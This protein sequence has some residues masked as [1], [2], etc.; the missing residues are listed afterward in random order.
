MS[1]VAPVWS[2]SD[3]QARDSRL[4]RFMQQ[5]GCAS[6]PE[7]C[8]KAAAEPR[9][10]WDALVK[11]LGIVWSTPYEAVMDTSAGVPFTRWFPGGRLNAYES[12]V[13]RH[14]R[15]D[16]DRLAIIAEN[17]GGAT[18]RLTYAEL[19]DAV[20]RTAAGLR[21]IGVERGV[22]VGLYLPL[23]LE[24]AVALLAITKLGAIA[25][26][27]FSGFGAEAVRQRISDAQARVLITADGATRRGRA[28]PMKPI[29]EQAIAGLPQAS[30]R[31]SFQGET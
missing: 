3:A 29:A 6:Y 17:E 15:T 7:L 19:E 18:R 1:A 14:Q 22:A 16:P 31:R 21:A 8:R 20:E 12:A 25:V 5:H 11:A 13:Q 30:I 9:W 4:S 10:F 27:L 23:V 26:P 28:V 24:N 2:P